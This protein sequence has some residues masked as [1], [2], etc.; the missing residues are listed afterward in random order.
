MLDIIL[1]IH[2]E[3]CSFSDSFGGSLGKVAQGT[4]SR[5]LLDMGSNMEAEKK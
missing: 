2:T 4:L 1:D 3:G 5:S